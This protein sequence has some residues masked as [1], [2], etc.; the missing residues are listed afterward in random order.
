[1]PTSLRIWQLLNLEPASTEF[2]KLLRLDEQEVVSRT[3][4]ELAALA[5]LLLLPLVI[6]FS[7]PAFINYLCLQKAL[8]ISVS[9][10]KEY[11]NKQ[12]DLLAVTPL[13]DMGIVIKVAQ[14]FCHSATTSLSGLI[15]IWL[16]IT[17]GCVF[18]FMVARFDIAKNLQATFVISVIVAALFIDYVQCLTWGV[19]VGIYTGLTTDTF[20]ARLFTFTSYLCLQ[21]L[22]YVSMFVSFLILTQSSSNTPTE[23]TI[24]RAVVGLALFFAVREG[25]ITFAWRQIRQRLNDD[26]PTLKPMMQR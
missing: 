3:W 13:G 7:L 9:L 25:I 23:Q 20:K 19:V 22:F 15:R 26:L 17:L 1:M 2:R 14:A 21:V 16:L 18:M 6:T 11:Q 5:F 12:Q 4:S 8:Q 24:F 10:S